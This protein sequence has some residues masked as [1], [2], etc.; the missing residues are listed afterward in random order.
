MLFR[1]SRTCRYWAP[2]SAAATS[3]FTKRTGGPGYGL[4]GQPHFGSIVGDAHRRLRNAA[5]SGDDSAGPP[6]HGLQ[7]EHRQ[8]AHAGSLGSGGLRGALGE[9]HA[10]DDKHPVAWSL[11]CRRAYGGKLLVALR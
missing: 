1:V 5:R 2:C 8:A 3:E 6:A 9:F 7:K 10:R 4:Y 11:P